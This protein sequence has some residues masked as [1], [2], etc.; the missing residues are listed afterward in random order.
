MFKV[1]DVRNDVTV[2]VVV[3]AGAG[4]DAAAGIVTVGVVT[5]I[6]AQTEIVWCTTWEDSANQWIAPL[7]GLDEEHPQMIKR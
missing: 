1:D 5:A 3:T 7:V 4:I 2:M 6:D